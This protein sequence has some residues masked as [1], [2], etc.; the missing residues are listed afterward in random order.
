MPEPRPFSSDGSFPTTRWSLILSARDGGE[1]AADAALEYLCRV[2]WHPVYAFVRSRGHGC[3]DAED[4]TQGFF[5]SLLRRPLVSLVSPESGRFRSFLYA[6]IKNYLANERRKR[7]A[8]KR[9]GNQIIFSVDFTEAEARWL[10][11]QSEDLD[12]S[13][14]F[15][16]QWSLSLL[17]TALKE[18]ETDYRDR[19]QEKLFEALREKVLED[20]ASASFREIAGRLEMEEGTVRV[21]ASRLRHRFRSCLRKQVEATVGSATEIEEE[22]SHLMSVFSRR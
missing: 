7:N 18:I 22:L 8:Q 16:R 14:L 13:T 5:E 2:Y 11:C 20:P 15:D 3:H 12:P 10:Q 4:L 19:G 1:R 21:A 6:S 17:Q 9:G